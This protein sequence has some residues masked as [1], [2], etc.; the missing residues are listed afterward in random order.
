MEPIHLTAASEDAG[1]R[2]DSFLA[3]SLPELTRSAAA[4]L[5]EAGQVLVNG[6]PVTKPGPDRA[7]VFQNYA[8]LP[9]LKVKDN[10]MYPM[11][12]QG[13]PRAERERR[14]QELLA[15]AQMEEKGLSAEQAQIEAFYKKDKEKI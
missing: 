1:T 6:S 13:V 2:L 12:K 14:L 11:K 3:A 10:I 9:W 7:F 8:L 5:I 15:I 4:R